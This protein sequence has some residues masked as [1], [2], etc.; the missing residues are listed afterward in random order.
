MVRY[1][2]LEDNRHVPLFIDV[3]PPEAER[4]GQ[5]KTAPD[6]AVLFSGYIRKI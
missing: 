6:G 2:M 3:I 4:N 1:R 5:K